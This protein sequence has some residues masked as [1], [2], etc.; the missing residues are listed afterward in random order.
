MKEKNYNTNHPDFKIP[1]SVVF[2]GPPASGKGTTASYLEN[3]YNI[4]SVSPGNIFKKIR[5]E[6]SE[7]SK[8]IIESTKDGGLC[9][10]WL[11]NEIVK[12]ESL[13]LIKLG[14]HSITLDGFPRTKQQLDFLNK[15]FDINLFVYS[16]THWMTLRKM[17][18]NRRNCKEC[19]KVFSIN[20]KLTCLNSSS[21]CALISK[22]NWETRWDDHPDF[23]AKRYNTYKKETLPVIKEVSKYSNFIKLDLF[24]EKNYETIISL[25]Q[26]LT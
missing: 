20:T 10:D 16:S 12:T 26:P 6:N 7:L 25:L 24:D 13:N 2:L 23:F 18:T 19:N 8:L 11:T 17:A 5:N 15:H 14:A 9:P 1:V 22:T 4:K 21:E 3:Q